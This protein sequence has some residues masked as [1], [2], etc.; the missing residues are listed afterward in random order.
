MSYGA[1]A[2]LQTAVFQRLSGWSGLSGVQVADA[3]PPASGTGTFVI[4]GPE[5]V[6]DQSDKSAGGRTIFLSSR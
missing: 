2:A 4:L 5:T 3:L 6:N 1:S